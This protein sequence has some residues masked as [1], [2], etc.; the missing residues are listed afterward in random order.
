VA[1]L[2]FL[3]VTRVTF[4]AFDPLWNRG[5]SS[6]KTK[7]RPPEA[8]PTNPYPGACRASVHFVRGSQ[9]GRQQLP[10]PVTADPRIFPGTPGPV[11]PLSGPK[12][13]SGPALT[14]AAPN[15]RAPSGGTTE[16]QLGPPGRQSGDGVQRGRSATD[17]HTR[18]GCPVHAGAE[19]PVR[20]G[21]PTRSPC[22]GFHPASNELS[23]W[24]LSQGRR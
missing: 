21:P 10:R 22:Q 9:A 23:S 17:R 2:L 13:E 24:K 7:K 8:W 4:V 12:P 1:L 5:V 19:G 3:L 16:Q 14:V 11:N 20:G 6:T 15:T 18:V